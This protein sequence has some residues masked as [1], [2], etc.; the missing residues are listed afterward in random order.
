[1]KTKQLSP[2]KSI[3]AKCLECCNGKPSMVRHCE[4]TDCA[5]HMYRFGKNP[6]RT[7]IGPGIRTKSET[8]SIKNAN[9]T[10]DSAIDPRNRGGSKASVQIS[11]HKAIIKEIVVDKAKMEKVKIL[12]KEIIGLTGEDSS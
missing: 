2:L 11:S 3:R 9:S 5:I 8:F 12:A 6:H 7:G 1:M 10:Q 4:S